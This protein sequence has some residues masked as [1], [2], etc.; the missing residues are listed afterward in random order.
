[1]YVNTRTHKRKKPRGCNHGVFALLLGF[2]LIVRRR[3][4]VQPLANEM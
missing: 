2:V 1:M 4:T 3:C